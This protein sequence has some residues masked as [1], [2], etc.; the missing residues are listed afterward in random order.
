MLCV[1]LE[2]MSREGELPVCEQSIESF[3][4]IVWLIEND[5]YLSIGREG[6]YPCAAV[7][8]D[9]HNMRIPVKLDSHSRRNWTAVPEQSGHPS[10]R[11]DA[12]VSVLL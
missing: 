1:G 3:K 11:S 4:N 7:A 10:E 8:T 2:I 12:G 9:E 6:P 5:G